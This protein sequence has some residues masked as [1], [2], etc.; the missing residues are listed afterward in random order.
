MDALLR[1]V[2]EYMNNYVWLGPFLALIAGM[3]T[4]L[5][6]CSLSQLPLII[7]YVTA[8]KGT[9]KDN[10]F[11]STFYALGITITFTLLGT[12]AGGTGQLLGALNRYWLIILGVIMTFMALETAEITHIMPTNNMISKNKKRGP[13]GAF[14]IGAISGLFASPCAT[15]VIIFL[16]TL[17]STKQNLAY[18]VMMMLMYSIG[19][20][21]ITIVAGSSVGFII[22]L[23]K[24]NKYRFFYTITKYM[25]ALVMLLMGLYLFYEGI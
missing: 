12:I 11:H 21:I 25:L 10:L 5:T 4:S 3:I 8:G 7:G 19:F 23:K 13:L 17:I 9:P 20:S 6:P 2:V 22:N 15:P 14:I 16:L 1:D 24:S 18:G